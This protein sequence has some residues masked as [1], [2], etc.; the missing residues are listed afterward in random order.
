MPV[1]RSPPKTKTKTASSGSLLSEF[2]KQSMFA[3]LERRETSERG[4]WDLFILDNY[5][6]PHMPNSWQA[7]IKMKDFG[8]SVL[9]VE[10]QDQFLCQADRQKTN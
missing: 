5:H 6:A 10:L 7:G 2:R 8:S 1:E 4:A 9:G 3:T